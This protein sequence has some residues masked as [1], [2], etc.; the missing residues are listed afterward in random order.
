MRCTLIRSPQ[1]LDKYVSAGYAVPPLGMAYVAGSLLAA[2]H[3]VTA[4]DT[5]GE[6]IDQ[7]EDIDGTSLRR[8]MSNAEI[9]DRIDPDVEVI[10]FSLMFSHDWPETRRLIGEIRERFAHAVM[11]GGGEHFTSDPVGAL[12]N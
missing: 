5:T 6:A 9:L 4:I 3:D 7:F 1:T 10:G 11:V 8:G 2:G 12:K